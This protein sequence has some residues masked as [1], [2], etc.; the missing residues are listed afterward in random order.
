MKPLEPVDKPCP[1]APV[2]HVQTV[3]RRIVRRFKQRAIRK[4]DTARD[5]ADA[6]RDAEV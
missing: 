3:D 4:F 5:R 6:G 1:L 2:R